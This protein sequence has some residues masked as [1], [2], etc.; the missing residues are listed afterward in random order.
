MGQ[1]GGRSGYVWERGVVTSVPASTLIL[2]QHTRADY[3]AYSRLSTGIPVG[4]VFHE[5]NRQAV[6]Q[7]LGG[8]FGNTNPFA[9]QQQQ[10]QQGQQQGAEQPF[11]QI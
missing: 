2:L 5:S 7:G 10:Q 11:F 3:S 9:R 8:G 6:Q 1:S 4:S